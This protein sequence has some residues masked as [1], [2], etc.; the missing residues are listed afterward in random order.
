[1]YDRDEWLRPWVETVPPPPLALARPATFR[2]ALLGGMIG[3][4]TVLV[5]SALVFGAPL[6]ITSD[7]RAP[8]I[9]VN[10]DGA[11]VP[12]IAA[13][14]TPSVVRVDVRTNN[15]N[16]EVSQRGGLGSGVVYSSDG[17][18]ITNF[19][20]IDGAQ[21]VRV[22]L[23]NGDAL[24]ARIVG[25]DQ[26]NDLA[27]LKISRTDLPAINL[28]PADEPIQV[29][30]TAIAIGSPFGLDASVSAGIISALDREL[31]IEA[32]AS[33][34]L[35][36]IPSVLQTDAAINPGNS[37]GP[38]VDRNGRLLGINTAILS[39]TGA[40]QGVGF[41]V[42]VEQVVISA[43]QIIA[44][45][46]VRHA[47]LG[48]SGTTISEARADELG[49]DQPRGAVVELVQEGS[50]A[51]LSGVRVGDVIIEVDGEELASMPE[52]V[53]MVRRRSPGD[54]IVLTILR[55]SETLFLSVELGERP[56]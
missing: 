37:G 2:S 36:T 6:V 3:A 24:D 19:H 44:N 56:R 31:R 5:L 18:I 10:G 7:T 4:V 45:G 27:V 29:G 23:A 22:R 49:L 34:G 38:L 51:D 55:D 47:L 16:G 14:V 46:F 52:L 39:G 42:S 8:I 40:N 41:A 26:L 9:E 33:E 50:G 12:A 30:E 25:S 54:T 20:V 1:M 15:Q 35:L 43:D 17:Y 21:Q 53:A 13:A 11:N 28:R 48:I 32:S